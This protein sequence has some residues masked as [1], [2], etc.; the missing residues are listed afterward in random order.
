MLGK[1]NESEHTVRYLPS[2]K[3]PE[4]GPREPETTVELPASYV[5]MK[6]AGGGVIEAPEIVA[7]YWGNFSSS[8]ITTMQSWFAGWASYIGDNAA[9]AGQDQVLLQYG[10]YTASVGVHYQQAS[11]PSTSTDAG[12]KAEIASLQAAGHLPAFS[13]NRIFVAMTKGIAFS[14]YGSTWCAYHGNWGGNEYYALC[15][16]PTSGGCEPTPTALGNLQY[17][18]SH[19]IMEGSTDPTPG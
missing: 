19:E 16:Y 8:E 1:V 17:A 2:R 12:L 18:V 10:V 5:P 9:P 6:W 14:G 3:P 7:F 15:P 11:A 13:S 4:A